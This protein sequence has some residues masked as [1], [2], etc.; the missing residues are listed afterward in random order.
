MLAGAFGFIGGGD[1]H[2]AVKGRGI[3]VPGGVVVGADQILKH[4]D[5]GAVLVDQSKLFGV[6]KTSKVTG[7]ANGDTHKSTPFLSQ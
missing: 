3:H 2:G 6:F 5:A 7:F 4:T 1:V